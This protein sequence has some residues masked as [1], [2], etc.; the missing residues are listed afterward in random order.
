MELG[1]VL[2]GYAVA[3]EA[4]MLLLLT[5]PGLESLRVGLVTAVRGTLKPLLLLLPLCLFLMVQV[6]WQCV[7]WPAVASEH[8]CTHSDNLQHEKSLVESNLNAILIATAFLLYWLL[9]SITNLLVRVHQ[10]GQQLETLK[11]KG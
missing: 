3:A 4:V 11:M 6:Y 7:C 2:L 9:F 8:G 10:L 1:W 5:I